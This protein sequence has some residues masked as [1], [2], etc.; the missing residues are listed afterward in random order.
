VLS[1]QVAREQEGFGENPVLRGRLLGL[2]YAGD[3]VSKETL[4]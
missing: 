4:E 2:R 1:Q 3:V